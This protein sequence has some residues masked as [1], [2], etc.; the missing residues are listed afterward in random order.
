MEE[1]IAAARKANINQFITN[2]PQVTLYCVSANYKT[3]LQGYETP[4][5]E[6][7]TQLSGGEYHS[8]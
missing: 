7:G 6:K 3:S 8:G 1:V 5:G 4:V 2:L